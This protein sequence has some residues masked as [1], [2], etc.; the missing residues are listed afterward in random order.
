MKI[1][2]VLAICLLA[3]CGD[4]NPTQTTTNKPLEYFSQPVAVASMVV[5]Q[6]GGIQAANLVITGVSRTPDTIILNF[7]ITVTNN[8]TEAQ[9]VNIEFSGRDR[10]NLEALKPVITASML[11]NET[12]IIN[13]QQQFNA[14]TNLR[15]LS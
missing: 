11:P 13:H 15:F 6:T 9:D 2:L 7:S 12:R 14:A 3:A 4:N 10:Y 1:V 5:D 8:N